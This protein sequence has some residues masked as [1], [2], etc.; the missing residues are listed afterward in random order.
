MSLRGFRVYSTRLSNGTF[1]VLV[2]SVNNS[3]LLVI[4]EGV[5]VEHSATTGE[6]LKRSYTKVA[7]GYGLMGIIRLT[8]DEPYL[9]LVTGVFSIGQLYDCD[10]YKITNVVFIPLCNEITEFLDARIVELQRLLSA[11][12]FYFAYSGSRG[13]VFDLTQSVQKRR[14]KSSLNNGFFWYKYNLNTSNWVA[15]CMCGSVLIRTIYVA[16]L[17]AKVAIL[18][19]LS[20]ERVGTRFN[21]RGAN[22]D[23]SVANFVETEQV[24]QTS[25]NGTAF[26]LQL[27]LFENR[28]S[29]FVQ[30]RGSVPLFWDQPGIQVG[31]HKVRLKPVEVSMPAFERHYRKL[32]QDYNTVTTINLLGSKEGE[33]L[34]STA[35]QSAFKSSTYRDQKFISFDYHAKMKSS[36]LAVQDLIRQIEMTLN[37]HNFCFISDDQNSNWVCSDELFG[38]F[39]SYKLRSNAN[40]I[41]STRCFVVAVLR[42]QVQDL[43]MDKIKDK[44]SLRFEEVMKDLWQK[45][46]GTGA[47]EG[48]SKLKDAGRSIARTIQN[49]LMDTAKQESFDIFLYGQTFG[50]IGFDRAN[51]ILR[52]SVLRECPYLVEE[53]V[54]RRSEFFN[55][56]QLK[57]FAGTWNVN[58]GKNVYNVAFRHE[59]S[60]NGWLF[61]NL[62][63]HVPYDIVAIGLEEIVDLNASNMMKASTTNQRV[64]RDGIKK[65][66]E[67]QYQNAESYVV[68][69]C[70]QLVGVCIIVYI[71]LELLSRMRELAISDVKTGLGGATGNKG[72]VAVRLTIDSTSICFVCSHFAA[73]QNEVA[74]RN[75]DFNTAWKKLRFQSGRSIESH[76]VIIWLGDFNYRISLNGEEVKA[77]VRAG[78]FALLNEYDQLNQQRGLENVF[79]GFREGPLNFA[80]TYKYDT[81]SDD[82]DTSEKCRSPAWTDRILWRDTQELPVYLTH[83]GRAELKTSDH[84]PVAATFS[85]SVSKI[86]RDKC[87]HVL[88][89]V[90]AA[91]GP[92]DGT[93]ICCVEGL[94]VFPEDAI[95]E[96]S[97][98][99]SELM[100]TPILTKCEG[101]FLWLVMSNGVD[102]VTATSMDGVR[103]GLGRVLHVRLKSENWTENFMS[104]LSG[105]F[106]SD[107]EVNEES[108]S[109]LAAMNLN[110]EDDDDETWTHIRPE[111][112]S[113]PPPISSTMLTNQDN[114]A[115]PASNGSTNPPIVP[116]RPTSYIQRSR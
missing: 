56:N 84:R 89:D 40:W 78:N 88:E 116:K 87:M 76:D 59:Q 101:Q 21:V 114:A 91:N 49:N 52:P 36:K 17:T 72:S 65:V 98:K 90:V 115:K 22:D 112:S 3:T 67:E 104:T 64:W 77:A 108:L 50:N 63:D 8:E 99:L 95:P 41:E 58:G 86:D 11:G 111:E 28:E 6:V 23:G 85:V 7:D 34:L 71:R 105:L 46:T 48:K 69:A 26:E 53:L 42:A 83:Y 45:K 12:I 1:S 75:D 61:P 47:L 10:I 5:I 27:I 92:P 82:Y 62:L 54:S 103:I 79:Q 102:A 93:A 107:A 32:K 73:G 94:N 100:I 9:I 13:N 113:I 74:N 37:E 33:R 57:V 66:L 14:S 43:E 106:E 25:F 110:L 2:E 96:V 29:S 16:H 70:E 19:R 4:Q 44:I 35:F 20:S 109:A 15:K 80:P 30:I 81:F 55:L 38:L 31:S 97:A 24:S 39:G 60:L 68:L 18:S 51:N